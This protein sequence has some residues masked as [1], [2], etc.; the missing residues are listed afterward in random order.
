[1]Q[2]K[3]AAPLGGDAIIEFDDNDEVSGA[4]KHYLR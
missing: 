4:F 1:M 3:I 2:I